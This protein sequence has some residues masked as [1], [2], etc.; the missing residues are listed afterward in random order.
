MKHVDS[1][2][3]PATSSAAALAEGEVA[4][5]PFE[6][7]PTHGRRASPVDRP[8]R[9]DLRL[10]GIALVVVGVS[11]AAIA[12]QL[13]HWRSRIHEIDSTFWVDE[14]RPGAELAMAGIALLNASD[15]LPRSR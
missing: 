9:L 3:A 15:R 6:D 7:D 4:S 14:S 1:P 10:V 11:V 13:V 2:T 5:S 12:K 8:E